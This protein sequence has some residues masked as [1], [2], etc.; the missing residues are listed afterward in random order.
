MNQDATVVFEGSSYSSASSSTTNSSSF[1]SSS[2][3]INN[4]DHRKRKRQQQQQQ[5]EEEEEEEETHTT[6]T[7]KTQETR[8]VLQAVLPYHCRRHCRALPLPRPLHV[9]PVHALLLH[10]NPILQ[11]TMSSSKTI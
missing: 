11:E 7:H 9:Y 8:A 6:H 10:E 2:P 5:Q 1:L 3:P 4:H